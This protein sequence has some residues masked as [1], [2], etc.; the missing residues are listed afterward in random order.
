MRW[1]PIPAWPRLCL[2]SLVLG[3]ALLHGAAA[4]PAA[5]AQR[6]YQAQWIWC[7][8]EMPPPFQF[9]RFRKTVELAS[10]PASATAY[11][12]ADT[13]YRLWVNGQ[14]AMHGPARSSRGKATVDFVAVGHLLVPGR[15][16]L[17]VEVFHGVCAF[18]ALAQAPGLFC[19]LEAEGDGKRQILAATDAT[20]E[21]SEI[22]AWDRQSL[23]FSY[24]RGWLE[25]YDAR[26]TS[27]ERTRPAVVL[28]QAGMAPWQNLQLRDIPLPAPLLAV[29][30]AAVVAVHRGDGFVGQVEPVARFD[31][32]GL[33][34]PEW[35]RRAEW[36]RRLETERVR[37]NAAAAANPEGVT[38][39]GAGDTLLA[40]EGAS[41]TYDLGL[42]HVGFIGFE[43][44]GRDGQV[45][46][47]AW[48]ERRAG[49]RTAR[50]RAQVGNNAHRYT[51]RE[52]RQSFLAFTPQFVR[53]LRVVQ[54]GT[55]QVR[56]HRL[57]LTEFRFAA[58]PKGS[59]QCSDDDLNRVYEAARRTAMLVTLDAYMDCPHRER[60]A[61]YA[62]EAYWALM[63]VFPMFGDTS[64][65]RRSVIY[66]AD[67]VDDPERTGPP[68]LIQ[69]AYPMQCWASGSV[70]L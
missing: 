63:A 68:G 35:E 5:Q 13:F 18:E 33:S 43:V 56:L 58:E 49:D 10:R 55:G 37:A 3:M 20:W 30:P 22:S 50:P 51:L 42:G 6:Q 39:Q 27:E 19:E 28:G 67:S 70:L 17:L 57:G 65:S 54:R 24:Q 44:S 41:I 61:M 4:L 8:A 46:E 1:N 66:G 25:Q 29:R 16:A 14:L 62:I 53:F 31:L 45:L 64:V 21:A 60:N 2:G 59:F 34:R 48:N 9:V 12:T 23:R 11:I 69:V 47:I 15:N 26:R 38:A 52:G 7:G 40:G 36:F 32:V